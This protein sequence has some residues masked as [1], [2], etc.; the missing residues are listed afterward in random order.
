ML[1]PPTAN[2]QTQHGCGPRTSSGQAVRLRREATRN[3][4][5]STDSTHVCECPDWVNGM[6]GS[7]IATECAALGVAPY[8]TMSKRP[9]SSDGA[10]AHLVLF[11]HTPFYLQQL[12]HKNLLRKRATG[13]TACSSGLDQKNK[14]GLKKQQQQRRP[15][16][17]ALAIATLG[18]HEVQSTGKRQP[19]SFHAAKHTGLSQLRADYP[20]LDWDA[21]SNLFP[22]L[23]RHVAWLQARYGTKS[24]DGVTPYRAAMGSD[25]Q[26]SLCSFGETVLSKLPRP[27][28]KSQVRWV[29]GVWAGKVERDDSHVVLT[30]AGAMKV[31]SVRRLP[32]EPTPDRRCAQGV[33]STAEPKVR[34][35]SA[36]RAQPA[37]HGPG[38]CGHTGR[39][40]GAARTARGTLPG[41]LFKD[42]PRPIGM[43]DLDSVEGAAVALSRKGTRQTPGR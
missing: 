10:V 21:S 15:V 26:G 41:Y 23:V 18:R 7:C 32:Q 16:C 5:P 6:W 40:G 43:V 1:V 11:S 13:S 12:Q 17:S 37:G 31:R 14:G 33:R 2:F 35:S 42:G 22:W 20:A 38:S 3:T 28:N 29:K 24:T 34:P 36:S 25:Y 39:G 19:S 9:R 30:E 4:T 8:T 27:G